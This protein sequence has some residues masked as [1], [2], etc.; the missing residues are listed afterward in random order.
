MDIETP[1]HSATGYQASGCSLSGHWKALGD[2]SRARLRLLVVPGSRQQVNGLWV[3]AMS[4]Y[5]RTTLEDTLVIDT[6]TP[7]V[8][9]SLTSCTQDSLVAD[10]NQSR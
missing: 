8:T 6:G 4:P 9:V 7:G 10:K 2:L 3:S 5:P 1:S